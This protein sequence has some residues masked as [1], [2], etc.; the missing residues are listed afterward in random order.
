[1]VGLPASVSTPAPQAL[2]KASNRADA[3]RRVAANG[4]V[5]VVITFLEEKPQMIK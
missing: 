3:A 1:M 5:K 4:E 2:S